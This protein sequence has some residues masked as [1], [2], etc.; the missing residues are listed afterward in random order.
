MVYDSLQGGPEPI[1]NSREAH[2]ED[3]DIPPQ[4]EPQR[5]DETEEGRAPQP[6]SDRPATEPLGDNEHGA[7]R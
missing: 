1:S 6:E 5:P 7:E 4:T 3:P 2:M